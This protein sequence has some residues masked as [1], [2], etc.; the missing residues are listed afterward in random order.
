M[1]VAQSQVMHEVPRQVLIVGDSLTAAC[2]DELLAAAEA[3]SV[4][5]VIRAEIGR[6]V[7]AVRP[8]LESTTQP[9]DIVVALGTNDYNLGFHAVARLVEGIMAAVGEDVQVWWID[10]ALT[11]G[12][13]ATFNLALWRAAE[14]QP[15]LRVISW[16]E[17]V[18]RTP[19]L[20]TEDGV[21]LTLEGRS[22]RTELVAAEVFALP[23]PG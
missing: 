6:G 13:G 7:R 9:T 5:L 2:E 16:A 3:A 15:G 11:E 12:R 22:A 14:E 20:L 21:H 8:I 18:S 23:L 4:D 17:V 10:L 1:G 19:G